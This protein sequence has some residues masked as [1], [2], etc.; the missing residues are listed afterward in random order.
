MTTIKKNASLNQKLTE[1]RPNT[2]KD[3]AFFMSA[4]EISLFVACCVMIN[5]LRGLEKTFKAGDITRTVFDDKSAALIDRL[6]E[7]VEA[8]RRF[9]IVFPVFGRG[10]FSPFFWAW[11]NWWDDYLKSLTPSQVAETERRARDGGSLMDDL[12]PKGHWLR[13]RKTPGLTLTSDSK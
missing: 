8:T 9:D 4:P 3:S 11:F 10:Q 1:P 2:E 5:E 12:R 13:Y 7:A 6:G